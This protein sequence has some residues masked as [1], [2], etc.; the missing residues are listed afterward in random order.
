[1]TMQGGYVG[2][3]KNIQYR[4]IE[5]QKL[6]QRNHRY[7]YDQFRSQP[8]GFKSDSTAAVVGTSNVLIT[9]RGGYDYQIGNANSDP[10]LVPSLD[11]TTGYLDVT[12]SAADGN[13][14]EYVQGGTGVRGRHRYTIGTDDTGP[15][16]FSRLQLKVTN[17]IGI[18]ALVFGFRKAQS[19]QAAYTS[20]TDYASIGWK[21]RPTDSEAYALINTLTNLNNGGQVAADSGLTFSSA[22]THT[23][24]VRVA[25]SGHMTSGVADGQG[26]TRFYFDGFPLGGEYPSGT[27]LGSTVT[28]T[29]SQSFQFD[30]TDTVHPFL[31]FVCA[32]VTDAPKVELVEWESG[33]LPR[34]DVGGV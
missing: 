18:T 7:T 1:M 14:A 22:E 8:L 19:F 26:N 32:T 33:F 20:Y 31:Y 29:T 11:A 30:N 16:F 17:P 27:P 3:G 4:S 21:T 25:D 23:F 24:E 13:Y 5:P 28:T 6:S 2:G 15:G 9:P 34:G 12:L 10:V